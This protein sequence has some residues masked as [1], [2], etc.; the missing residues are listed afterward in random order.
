MALWMPSPYT[1][2]LLLTANLL[3][4]R[5]LFRCEGGLLPLWGGRWKGANRFE[6]GRVRCSLGNEL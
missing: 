4:T 3:R 1:G 2:M 5:D 6:A